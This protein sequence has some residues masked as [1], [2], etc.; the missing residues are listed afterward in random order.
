LLT[1]PQLAVAN[2]YLWAVVPWVIV[3]GFACLVLLS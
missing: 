1:W 2:K 3:A